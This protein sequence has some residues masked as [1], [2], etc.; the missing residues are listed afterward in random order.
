MSTLDDQIEEFLSARHFAVA[1]ASDNPE[2]Y[3]H[4]CFAALQNSGRNVYPIHPVAQT[5]L[6]QA[7]FTSLS[8]IPQPVE[9]LSIVTSPA[10]TEKL[11][12]EAIAAGV[13]NI[14]MQPGAESPAAVEKATQA[15]L[16]VISGGPCLLVT[17]ATRKK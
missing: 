9:S 4:K 10:V 12:D 14:W 11:V 16:N 15:G 7:A 6:G 5:V 17:L 13:K 2:K 8:A 3:G 1:G